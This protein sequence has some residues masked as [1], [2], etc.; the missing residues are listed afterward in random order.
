MPGDNK[1]YKY[2]VV[3]PFN[4]LSIS[5]ITVIILLILSLYGWDVKQRT[6]GSNF[7]LAIYDILEIGVASISLWFI[8]Q[9]FYWLKVES[10]FNMIGILLSL[11]SISTSFVTTLEPASMQSLTHILT[12]SIWIF[13]AFWA[14]RETYNNVSN[15]FISEWGQ[16]GEDTEIEYLEQH[17]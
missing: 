3:Y 8:V 7:L 10:V 2:F 11:A 15:L 16:G 14:W 12:L 6:S 9:K 1:F 4:V 13:S 17:F 5:K